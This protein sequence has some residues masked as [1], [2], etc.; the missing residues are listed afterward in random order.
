MKNI[1]K[2]ILNEETEGLRERFI[3]SA[4]SL[5]YIIESV[6]D[7]KLID[8]VEIRNINY[9]D[10]NNTINGELIITSWHEDPE[11]LTFRHQLGRVNKEIDRV[12]MNY[13]FTSN[14]VF[15][16]NKG[17]NNNLM[18]WFFGCEWNSSSN[19]YELIMKY[20]FRQED[21]GSE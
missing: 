12:L 10:K 13:S 3:R 8:G 7:S 14:G 19:N 21:Y 17:K 15:G 16:K 20:E 6:V 1:I 18:W 11:V 4:E 5:P 9:D 2:N